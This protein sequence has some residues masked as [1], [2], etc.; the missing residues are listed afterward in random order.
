MDDEDLDR[1]LVAIQNL[2]V[3]SDVGIKPKFLSR[4]L[5]TFAKKLKKKKLKPSDL[6][7]FA[8]ELHVGKKAKKLKKKR[9]KKVDKAI[10]K[11]EKEDKTNVSTA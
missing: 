7:K 10:K 6:R 3:R 4:E 11:M 2:P 9:A 1:M 5:E 8:K